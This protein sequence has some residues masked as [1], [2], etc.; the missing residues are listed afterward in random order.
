MTPSKGKVS[1][2]SDSTKV[3]IILMFDLFCRFFWI[4]FLPRPPFLPASVVVVD[5][6]GTWKYIKLLSFIFNFS[7]FS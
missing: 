6:I 3:L 5:F 7:F 1:D 2:S 4:F